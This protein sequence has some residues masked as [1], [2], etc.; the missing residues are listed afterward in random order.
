MINNLSVFFASFRKLCQ[1]WRG[2]G[3]RYA[4]T[5]NIIT[6]LHSSI[7]VSSAWITPGLCP[8]PIHGGLTAS[9]PTKTK[10]SSN[11]IHYLFLHPFKIFILDSRWLIRKTRQGTHLREAS[12]PLKFQQI[13]RL[14]QLLHYPIPPS[15]IRQH[16]KT[17][18]D[19]WWQTQQLYNANCKWKFL[20]N[21]RAFL[22]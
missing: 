4:E 1:N 9:S 13:T 16:Q 5:F 17:R 15:Q 22:W 3:P 2:S 11:S 19:Y 10:P 21:Q 6:T 18:Q 7:R 14:R 20:G 12:V 8:S